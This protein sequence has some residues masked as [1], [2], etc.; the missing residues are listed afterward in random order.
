MSGLAAIC[1][2]APS[3]RPTRSVISLTPPT[4]GDQLN[5]NLLAAG[6]PLAEV[7]READRGLAF[8]Q[9]MRFGLVIDLI[10]P[11]LGLIR[12]LRGLT[13]TFGCFD[14][15]QFDEARI[16]RHFSG[17]PDLAFAECWYWIRKL[18]ALFFAADYAGAFYA[19]SRAQRVLWTSV[20]QLETA[21]YHFYA[22]LSHAA[23]YDSAAA[24]ERQQHLDAVA[25]HHEKLYVWAGNCPDNFENRAALV[26]AEIA[27]IEGRELDAERLYEQAIRSA[28]DH[29]FVQN[30]GLAHE[31]AARFYTTRGFE[32]TANAY[33]RNA[34]HSYLR[35][36]AD[37]KVRQLDRLHPHLAAAE[38]NSP[39]AIAGSPIQQLDVAI[40]VKASQAVS[41]EIVLSTLIERLMTIALENAGA[42][43]GLLIL[44][45][46]DDYLIQAEAKATG[47]QVEVG[48]GQ[49][50]ITGITCP[51]SIVRYVMRT[52]ESVTL[53]DASRPNLFSEDDYLRSRQAKSILCLPLIKQGRLTGLL[54]LENTLTSHAFAADRIAIL[55]LLA[56]QAAISLENTR[57]Y[58]D[59]QEREAKVRRLI[60]S[61]IIG[62]F[63]WDFEGRII[64]ANEAFLHMVGQSRDDLV[65]GRVRW[66]AL[67]PADWHDASE[68]AVAELRATGATKTYEKEFFRKDGTRVPILI[69]SATFGAARD[70]GVAFVLDLTERKQAEASLEEILTFERLLADL[71]ARFADNSIVQVET[72]IDSALT[73]LQEFLGFDRSN[74]FEFA[75][76]G[77]ATIIGSVA[78][79]GVQRHPLGPAPA[80]LSWYLGQVR[81]G[82]IM[83]VQSIGDLPPEAVEQIAYH[84]QVGIRSSLGIPLRVGGRIVGVITFAAFGSTRKWSDDLVTRLKVIGE[85]MAQTLMRKRAEDALRESEQQFRDFAEAASDWYWETGPDHRFITHLVSEQQLKT[86]GVLTTSR[87]GKVRW[88]FAQDIEEEPEK[89]RQH[90][91]DLDAHKPFRDFRYR[92]ASRDGSEV[93][94]AASGKPIFDPKGNFLGYRG[95]AS[96][97]SAAV[98]AALLEEALQEAK[99][100]GD[101][102]A[103]D[104]RTPLTRVRLRLERGREHAATL[105]EM[106][107][108]ADRAIGGLDQ[109]LATITA[110][111]RITEIEHS[112]RHEAFSEVELAPLTSRGGRSL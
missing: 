26:G 76:D 104:L 71:S 47:D 68:R 77:R 83:R 74:F 91:A 66:T 75:A 34:R 59:L 50:S 99:V 57:L 52:Q 95:V 41:S 60:D 17:N 10:A 89:W 1:C 107:E 103:H 15:A 70:E 40:V 9:K 112:R 53:D 32:T 86:V 54:Y 18:Q 35:W 64:E 102:I 73:Q 4:A 23:F 13:P 19:S 96:H 2:A 69:G 108:V 6:D 45:V 8:A 84:R 24:G 93:Y 105:E 31:L 78:R 110:L 67:T 56:A 5:T 97:I 90:I 30:E 49:K 25:A 39:A 100:V 87:I 111:L 51:E 63:I 12:T 44:P 14:D 106:R 43:R 94:I 33:L 55:E 42:D 92:A 109:S 22:A 81:A 62:I 36:G 58:S 37:G 7:E 101:N 48:L 20:S 16:E 88:D 29:G 28:R 27:R 80:F 61:N 85:V 46:E 72:E 3:R 11:Q 38:W 79:A 21:E 98:R 65:S 82:K